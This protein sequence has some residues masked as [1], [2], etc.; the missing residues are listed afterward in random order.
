MTWWW[1]KEINRNYPICGIVLYKSGIQVKRIE[2]Y[3][4]CGGGP[5]SQRPQGGRKDRPIVTLSDKS[6]SRLAFVATNTRVIFKSMMTLTYPFTYPSDGKEVKKDLNKFLVYSQRKW[7]K[8]SY[9]W[10]LE[11]Q[12]RG[13]PHIHILTTEYVVGYRKR[14]EFAE[15]WARIASCTADD[16]RKTR[17]VHEHPGAW[18]EIRSEHGAKAYVLKYALKPWQK[19]VPKEYQNVGRFWGTSKD[20]TPKAKRNVPANEASVRALL[21]SIGHPAHKWTVIPHFI[22][23]REDTPG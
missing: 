9:L 23:L 8:Y 14:S 5:T 2:G 15:M 7:D 12:K 13:A 19:E 17:A 21:K 11:F 6:L 22:Y 3:T 1:P 4:M 10:F 16:Y 18:D 20:V